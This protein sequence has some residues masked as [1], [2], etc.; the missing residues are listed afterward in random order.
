MKYF[1]TKDKHNW[2]D[3]N[4]V[5]V[6]FSNRDCCCENWGYFYSTTQPKRGLTSNIGPTA[7]DLA[8]Y[9]FDKEYFHEAEGKE[10]NEY[11]NGGAVTFKLICQNKPDIYLTLFN[12]HNGYYSH[13]FEMQQNKT[14][15]KEGSI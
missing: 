1:E 2:I 9:N 14:T 10:R 3:E 13:G 7:D 11:D 12:I 8:P 15:I 5:F 4:N 6:G